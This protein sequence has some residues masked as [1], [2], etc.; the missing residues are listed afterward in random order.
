VPEP[1]DVVVGLDAG[2]T[3]AKFVALDRAGDVVAA[4]ASDAIITA[5]PSPGAS[6]QK[7]SDI[8][9][10]LATACRRGCQAL[11]A[12]ARIY[13]VSIA[14]QSGS[15]LPIDRDDRAVEAITWMDTRSQPLVDSW[16]ARTVA[17]IR[18]RSGWMPT[19]GLGLSTISWIRAHPDAAYDR[20]ERWASVDDYLVSR[21]TDSWLT[22]PSN[23]TGMQ[24]VDVSSM[25]WSNELCDIAGIDPS[26]LSKIRR[27]G[28]PAG[29]ITRDAARATGLPESTPVVIGGH[30]QAC[31]ALG[32]GV[33][34]PGSALLS[35]GTA[36]VLTMVTDRP[37]LTGLP[38]GFNLS[39]HVAADLWSVSQNLGGLGAALAW[40]LADDVDVDD[41]D[42]DDLDERLGARSRTT[43][44]MFF[45]PAIHD[46]ERTGWGRFTDGAAGGPIDR[47]RAVMEANA[48][49]A[50]RTLDEAAPSVT[51]RDLT[52]TGGGTR[53]SYLTQLIADVV[54]VTLT[55]R[56]DA[57]WPAI[58]A[59]MLAAT[60]C[61]WPH[62]AGS[63]I[64]APTIRPRTE[65]SDLL[66]SRYNEY[67]RL[68]SRPPSEGA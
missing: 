61:E 25:Q 53:S 68:T 59:A 26:M 6:I 51:L 19:A 41:D 30:D 2:T 34:A 21:L 49:E 58:G 44:D 35:M 39:P 7:P 45:V 47:V 10:A 8:W 9:D 18:A 50:R 28:R 65:S 67:R 5:T 15:V 24:L 42:G 40:A 55:A 33:V 1:V 12:S 56:P 64:P 14:A 60:S 37:D 27:S 23:A 29:P 20:Y 32:L 43:D 38:E 31:A 54:G 36:W 57:S 11:P 52:I 48:F 62:R 63:A 17:D 3:S 13:G 4:A 46:A 66:E 22:N 16:N